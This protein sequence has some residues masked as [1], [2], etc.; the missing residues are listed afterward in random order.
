M[1]MD[2]IQMSQFKFE[3]IITF[4]SELIIVSLGGIWTQTQPGSKPPCKPLSY[5]ELIWMVILCQIVPVA[6]PI[7]IAALLFTLNFYFDIDIMSPLVK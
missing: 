6:T 5:D 4:Y 3:L 7:K 2:W 1:R